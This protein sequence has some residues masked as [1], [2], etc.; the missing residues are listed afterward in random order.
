MGGQ[1]NES[2]L[3]NQ[4][5]LDPLAKIMERLA[6]LEEERQMAE[7]RLTEEFRQKKDLDDFYYREKRNVLEEAAGLVQRSVVG[8]DVNGNGSG[9]NDGGIGGGGGGG[10]F[11]R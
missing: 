9:D 5:T 1:W 8:V 2:I 6:L 10:N 11:F 3:T 7:D 4:E